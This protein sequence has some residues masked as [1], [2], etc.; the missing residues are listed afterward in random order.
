MTLKDITLIW[1]IGI[2]VAWFQI[3]YWNRKKELIC[4]YDYIS[5]A[6][7]SMLSWAIY[8]IYLLEWLHEQINKK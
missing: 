1:I 8:P 6:Y 3:K 2:I 7:V 5:L 4:P